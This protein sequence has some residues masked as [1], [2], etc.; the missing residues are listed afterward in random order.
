[1]DT[2]GSWVGG[3]GRT[4]ANHRISDRVAQF[5][6][7]NRVQVVAV[8]VLMTILLLVFALQQEVHT[9]F[10]DLVPPDHPYILTHETFKESFGGSNIVS[11]MV[12]AEDGEIFQQ[13]VLEV[14]RDITRDLREVTG[15]NEFQIISLASKKLKEVHASTYGIESK[16]LMWPNVPEGQVALDTLRQSVLSNPLV[17]GQ[18]VSV[19]LTSGLITVDFFDRLMDYRV[20][21]AEVMEIV[22]KYNGNGVE[23]SV[24]G[25]PILQGWVHHYLPQ[26]FTLFVLTFVAL[27]AILYFVF[28]RTLRGTLI[29]LLNAL[30]TGTWALGIA[31]ILGLNFDPLAVVI[32]FLIT[33][34]VTS[35]CVQAVT[36]FE[37]MVS[38]GAETSRAAAQASLAELWKP[39]ILSVITDAGGILVVAFAP[40][41]LLQKTAL[42]GAIWVLCIGVTGVVLTPVLLSWVPDPKPR[43]HR[44]DVN[45]LLARSLANYAT[46]TTGRGRFVVL[47]ITILVLVICGGIATRISVGDA[48]PG[49]PLLWP[50]SAY[51]RAMEEINRGFLGTDRMFV[52]VAGEKEG[53]LQEPEIL[54]NMAQ[55]Q[56]YVEL[57]PEVGGAISLADLLP[58]VYSVLNEGNPRFLEI[59]GDAATNGELLYMYMAGSDPGDL[60]RFSDV[61]YRNGAVTI[62]LR[63]HR[64]STIRTAVDRIKYYAENNTPEG[65]EY[66]LAGGLIGVV[67]AVNEVIF[68][69][70]I[71]SIALALLV[72]LITCSVTYRSGVAGVFFMVPVVLSNVVTFAYMVFKDI[73]LNVS[74]LPVAAL[75][76]G[77]GV[78][79]AIYMVDSIR[80]NYSR[81][82]DLTTAIRAAYTTAGRGVA[83]TA[84]PL[85]ACTALWYF[86]S[87][88]RFQAEMAILIAL[89]M[90]VS[91]ASALFV[92]PA[93]VYTFR[94]G[95][96]VN[97]RQ[98]EE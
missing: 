82:G 27:G 75:G 15:V 26:T 18:Y 70:Q 97:N 92:M 79:Y 54:H 29:P 58:S 77:L 9:T 81:G 35:H 19:D 76:I 39:G 65:V 11:I 16:P 36:R 34:R 89:W 30:I 24:V 98:R 46:I 67:A 5:C 45:P 7:S 48:K 78:D 62:F 43:K 69:G 63:D 90:A 72:I 37:G 55:F 57:Q 53:S 44:F 6:I 64:G 40:I 73:G 31:K 94:P 25:E 59:G 14:I 28:M 71:E 74:T 42:I 61:N 49:S 93:L 23:V 91:A 17:Y 68:A 50:D 88:L 21:Y 85:I 83:V 32:A 56:R 2:G 10:A 13:S 86:F 96:V 8:I 4:M 12:R 60:D 1:V 84:T 80:E 22:E 20:V 51:N 52:V 66:Q 33:A 3:R 38:E 95:F 41:P 47:G 87:S